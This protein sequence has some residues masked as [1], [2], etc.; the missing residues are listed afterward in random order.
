MGFLNFQLPD[1]GTFTVSVDVTDANGDVG[2]DSVTFDVANVAPAGQIVTGNGFTFRIGNGSPTLQASVVDPGVLDTESGVWSFT[3]NGSPY[4]ISGSTTGMS[5]S[6]GPSLTEAGVYIAT[7]V[8]TDDD[9]GSVTLVSQPIICSE[10][11]INVRGAVYMGTGSALQ[12]W[13][14]VTVYA[15]LNNDGEYEA[16]EPAS[17]TSDIAYGLG[18][19]SY[20][21]SGLDL[22]TPVALRAAVDTDGLVDPD[23]ALQYLSTSS[24]SDGYGG[25]IVNFKLMP[26]LGF[27]TAQPTFAMNPGNARLDDIS[28][29]LWTKGDLVVNG[30]KAHTD[31]VY[32]TVLFKP[33]DLY[34][35]SSNVS[36][37]QVEAIGDT[38]DGGSN[39]AF[40]REGNLLRTNY[41]PNDSAVSKVSLDGK[42]VAEN[43]ITTQL[44]C[45]IEDVEV[46]V[47]GNIYISVNSNTRTDAEY[48]GVLE[49]QGIYEF[50]SSGS[51]LSWLV[52]G[53]RVDEFAVAPDQHTIIFGQGAGGDSGA[54]Y[55][56][57]AN[58]G[59]VVELARHLGYQGPGLPD[60][61]INAI[62]IV[63]EGSSP[64]DWKI[65]VADSAAFDVV[66][67]SGKILHNW[68][69]PYSYDDGHQLNSLAVV[70]DG[71][72]VWGTVSYY[73]S[74]GSAGELWEFNYDTGFRI[75]A[76]QVGDILSDM[77]GIT[78]SN[79][80]TG[81]VG[82]SYVYDPALTWGAFNT[83]AAVTY[84]HSAPTALFSLAEAPTGAHIDKATGHIEWTPTAPGVYTFEIVATPVIGGSL[85][86]DSDQSYPFTVTVTQGGPDGT[87]VIAD[88]R[89]SEGRTGLHYNG[90]VVASDPN[91]DELTYSIVRGNTPAT[92][93]SISGEISFVPTTAGDKVFQVQVEDGRGGSAV[94]NIVVPISPPQSSLDHAPEFHGTLQSSYTLSPGE[95][96]SISADS[97]DIVLYDP[98]LQ[99]KFQ[100]SF[101]AIS[102]PAGFIARQDYAYFNDVLQFRG[103]LAWIPSLSD[104]GKSYTVV[105]QVNDNRGGYTTKD[106]TLTVG[107]GAPTIDNT[108]VHVPGADPT[109][110][111]TFIVQSIDPQVINQ[112]TFNWTWT[113]DDGRPAPKIFGLQ[114][115]SSVDVTFYAAGTYHFSVTATYTPPG[116]S[117]QTSSP[118]TFCYTVEQVATR[119]TPTVR[120]LV[121]TAGEHTYLPTPHVFDQFD[122][123]MSIPSGDTVEWRYVGTS[124]LSAVLDGSTGQ[125]NVPDGISGPYPGPDFVRVQLFPPTGGSIPIAST[126]MSIVLASQGL[127]GTISTGLRAIEGETR[128]FDG[129]NG[130]DNFLG[131]FVDT[132]VSTITPADYQVAISWGDGSTSTGVIVPLSG[133]GISISDAP[134]GYSFIKG[135]HTYSKSQYYPI[136]ITVEKISS[137]EK[138]TFSSGRPSDDYSIYPEDQ[139]L[140]QLAPITADA[141][142]VQVVNGQSFS[143]VLATFSDPGPV[144]D[145]TN[146]EA[147]IDWGDGSNSKKETLGTDY[148]ITAIGRGLYQII[149]NH[150]YLGE[151]T[152][153]A[154]LK[155][156]EFSRPNLL[157][158]ETWIVAAAIDLDISVDSGNI[159]QPEVPTATV[160]SPTLV[161]VSWPKN[162]GTAGYLL[163][164]IQYDSDGNVL[165]TTTLPLTGYTTSNPYVDSGLEP[166]SRYAYTVTA[167]DVYLDQSMPSAPSDI[168]TT[169]VY[170]NAIAAVPQY[171]TGVATVIHD[172]NLDSPETGIQVTWKSSD[173]TAGFGY[174]IMRQDG[175]S[176]SLADLLPSGKYIDP[177]DVDADG[178]ISYFDKFEGNPFTSTIHQYT[179]EVYAVEINPTD[180]NGVVI[181]N[182]S[183]TCDVVPGATL[184]A[185]TG[186]QAASYPQA[187]QLTWDDRPS[188]ED[189]A[190]A[191][192]N[193]YRKNAGDSD[194][195]YRRLNL[196]PI[197]LNTGYNDFDALE[198]HSYD[199]YITAVDLFGGESAATSVVLH[200]RSTHGEP[201]V[202]T[203]LSALPNG[204]TGIV[205]SWAVETPIQ[206]GGHLGDA[207]SHYNVYR[208]TTANFTPN[209]SNRVADDLT[210][211][212][213]TDSGLSASH[214]YY[215]AV[216]AVD[217]DEDESNPATIS[218]HTGDGVL[219]AV[220]TLTVQTISASSVA[221]TFA[222]GTTGSG[223]DATTGYIFYRSDVAAGPYVKISG[224]SPITGTTY[225]DTTASPSSSYSYLLYAVDA[226]G[227]VSNST[228]SSSAYHLV[229][230]LALTGTIAPPYVA[231]TSPSA[232]SAS[233]RILNADT[234]VEGVVVDPYNDLDEW[235]LVLRLHGDAGPGTGAL[236]GS[237]DILLSQGN[238]TVGSIVDDSPVGA[239]MGTIRPELVPDGLYDVI[240]IAR[241][242]VGIISSPALVAV[243]IKS[244]VKAGNFTLPVSDLQIDSPSGQS[245]SVTRVY[246][247]LQANDKGDFGYGWKL[248]L[249]D[250]NYR[251]TA[252]PAT[253]GF[254]GDTLRFGD[255]IYV[256][257]PG[258]GQH[259]FA[260]TPRRLITIPRSLLIR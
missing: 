119:L 2:S 102:K 83:P 81:K 177:S 259:V 96:W 225:T 46:D 164:R 23:A 254:S 207:L 63:A 212:T 72:Y 215:Y 54:I 134:A 36:P 42:T 192:W 224:N 64:D 44:D 190:F 20:S 208:S 241:D 257:I 248:Q 38:L 32:Q 211:A 202:P 253:A 140:V 74:S 31:G 57:D 237:Q 150:S 173:H 122:D 238:S 217:V 147:E 30:L 240:L 97:G 184:A 53:V 17:I 113:D 86:E 220:P 161:K 233:P 40:D 51:L 115:K 132:T 120:S 67:W 60:G 250:T 75:Q 68:V 137:G 9:G 247:T 204:A 129:E 39:L 93:D 235:F 69:V 76:Q 213:F 153:D 151:G 117:P 95:I 1:N 171:L 166:N 245:I 21:L 260:F 82:Q 56:L 94:A 203:D 85:T 197:S 222:A 256:T 47:A 231:I 195:T 33:E 108:V 160:V 182:G 80:Q 26:K 175:S 229:N 163:T 205:L 162:N 236:V 178:N 99:D 158:A 62:R 249:S 167:V 143:R 126:I 19:G 79:L 219:P 146:F 258:E 141:I 52:P 77:D 214:T 65:L 7:C 125:F 58:T 130:Q 10:G 6:I 28:D 29:P 218:A 121:V 136:S 87:P 210:S 142:P 179:Y 156:Y 230:T 5:V 92:I 27:A 221:F 105:L 41:N 149:G 181:I 155:I 154:S 206:D 148:T 139:L 49:R 18:V 180:S 111:E 89:L 15:D 239:S 188:A 114:N 13:P 185:P 8:V 176:G 234:P 196:L 66:S 252:S 43:F 244:D 168:V 152:V 3:L 199:Y 12:V 243:Q 71:P 25:Y 127:A 106:I 123:S 101:E 145:V 110:Q 22:S 112:A 98:D 11:T 228:A 246:D 107:A 104:I 226:D 128:T 103:E 45:S 251:T 131:T 109:R 91:R 37:D 209:A 73:S 88:Q 255:L 118:V 157:V 174:R 59:D 90:L 70:P 242:K 4:T 50:D 165:S 24:T 14:E 169:T 159:A 55:K 189:S 133:S 223:V 183:A 16:N 116:G 216:T 84:Y 170:I 78:I 194:T 144:S 193:V 232:G 227:D 186:L 198:Q 200:K 34:P 61:V 35:G 135:T 124:Y 191:G 48:P 187:I 201:T 100:L 172:P 138:V